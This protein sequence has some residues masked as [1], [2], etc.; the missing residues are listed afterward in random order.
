T[1]EDFL[2]QT[3]LVYN[4]ADL[5]VDRAPEILNQVGFPT[6]FFSTIATLN[7]SRNKYSLQFIGLAQIVA[8]K[9]AMMVKQ[10]L[11]CKR[12]DRFSDQIQPMIPTPGHGAFPSAHA[13]EAFIVAR[14]L[15]HL[16]HG[17]VDN[18]PKINDMLLKQASRIAINRHV[19][20]VHFPADTYAG[21]VMGLTLGD[22]LCRRAGANTD[23][24]RV[25][26]NAEGIGAADFALSNFFNN[27]KIEEWR[28]PDGAT[29][30]P[31]ANIDD[32]HPSDLVHWL[33]RKA[34]LEW[35]DA[36]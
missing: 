8:A 30:E 26:F 12:P 5:R 9:T 34:R 23:V 1:P 13:V 25:S 19:A 35:D 28:A 16:L 3:K 18:L 27:G 4:Y 11:A 21:A 17:K 2:A 15:A 33:W 10:A 22:Y 36:N 29:I 32:V 14:V 6:V 31:K 24:T 7:P 20:G